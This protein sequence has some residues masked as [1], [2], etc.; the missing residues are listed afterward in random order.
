MDLEQYLRQFQI[1]G[2]SPELR[3]RVLTPPPRTFRG[4]WFWAS[5][6][7]SIA[8][9]VGIG[10]WTFLKDREKPETIDAFSGTTP[11]NILDGRGRLLPVTRETVFTLID[12]ARGQVRLD[13]GELLVEIQPGSGARAEVHTSAGVVRSRCPFLAHCASKKEPAGTLLVVAP[14]GGEVEVSNRHGQTVCDAG[15]VVFV[16]AE[17]APERHSE[18]GGTAC[19]FASALGLVYRPEVQR[20]LKLTE[21]QK[22]RLQQPGQEELRKVCD[23][24]RGL[25]SVPKTE[26]TKQST[27]FCAAQQQKLA[28]VLDAGQQKRLR[29]IALQQEGFFAVARPE[30]ASELKLT[31]KQTARV[32]AILREFGEWYRSAP[33]EEMV[34]RLQERQRQATD[35]IAGVLMDEQRKQWEL[36]IGE[37]FSL[38]RQRHPEASEQ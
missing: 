16:V 13:E 18:H 7:A 27:E 10:A 19:P 12:A 17:S 36:L 11:V 14:L 2:P 15:E 24:F 9:A 38:P 6:A 25:R 1:K 35:A 20:E 32:Q 37:R 31:P 23:F 8:V 33:K 29:Q 34:Q 4:P 5:V 30:V 28:G 22:T 3:S 21:E 26:W